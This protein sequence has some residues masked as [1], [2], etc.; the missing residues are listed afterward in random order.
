MFLHVSISLEHFEVADG[1]KIFEEGFKHLKVMT[2]DSLITCRISTNEVAA[3]LTSLPARRGNQDTSTI[4]SGLA[5]VFSQAIDHSELLG[6]ITYYWNYHC[7]YLLD[8]TANEFNVEGVQMKVEAYKENLQFF[9]EQT[10]LKAFCQMEKKRPRPPYFS[11]IVAEFQW[12]NDV[13]LQRVEEFRKDFVQYY[14]LHDYCMILAFIQLMESSSSFR[15]TW[16]IP[17]L[18]ID[19]VKADMPEELIETHLI[20]RVQIAEDSMVPHGK[21]KQQVCNS[22]L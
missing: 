2:R 8:Y 7:Y 12:P 15:V 18:V 10:L 16:F 4:L 1:I 3:Y 21:F 9:K 11:E 13:T 19:V 6:A 17:D 14:K 22:W 20:T 5:T